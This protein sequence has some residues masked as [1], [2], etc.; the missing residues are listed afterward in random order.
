MNKDFLSSLKPLNAQRLQKS[1]KAT[2]QR[3]GRLTFAMDAVKSMK[4][5]EEKG[6]VIFN[7]RSEDVR[8]GDLFAVLSTKDDP[9]AFA[10][11]RCGAYFYITFKNYLEQE[12]VDFRRMRVS[13]DITELDEE[14]DGKTL[15]KFER[16]MRPMGGK[17]DED[18]SS[19]SSSS[20]QAEEPEDVTGADG[21]SPSA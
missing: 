1:V 13:Y 20:S 12:G 7:S 15:Y 6:I 19:S 18:E 5:S 14:Y 8:P 11:K 9:N 3:T 10:L 4:L 2:V 16:R 21:R 17:D